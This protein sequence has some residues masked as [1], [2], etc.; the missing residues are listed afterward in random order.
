[1]YRRQKLLLGLLESFGGDLPSTD[2]QKYLFLY[3]R[4]CEKDHSYEFVPYKYGCFSFQSYSD[5]SKLIDLGYL[6]DSSDWRLTHSR[7]SHIKQLSKD[8]D[9]KLTLFNKKYSSLKGEKLLQHVY[10]GYPYYAINSLVAEEI[11]SVAEYAKIKRLKVNR[12]QNF[13]STIGYEGITVEQYINT[14]IENDIHL[15]VDVRKNPLSRKFGFSKSRLSDLLGKVGIDYQHMPELGIV[16]DKRKKLVSK[17]DYQRLFDEYEN[18]VLVDEN[19]A[20]TALHETYLSG[21]RIAL[22]CFEESHTMCHR[23]NVAKAVSRLASE[24]FK[25]AHL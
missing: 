8:E 1:M 3:T 2:F 6:E 7:N 11:L 12:C 9:K 14:L 20:I 13:F 18:T 24:D 23:N 5:K 22:T 25:V 10:T 15:L 16:S 19:D 4:L 17:S 21:K